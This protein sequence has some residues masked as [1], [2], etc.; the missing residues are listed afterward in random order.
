MVQAGGGRAEDGCGEVLG[1]EGKG[2]RRS[3]GVA[4]EENDGG[5]RRGGGVCGGD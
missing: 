5:D 1:E 2:L 3:G 4:P